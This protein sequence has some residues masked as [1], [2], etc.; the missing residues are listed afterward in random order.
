M[1]FFRIQPHLAIPWLHIETIGENPY[2]QEFSRLV[3]TVIVFAVKNS[4]PRAHHLD[5][6][7]ADDLL[8]PHIVFVD[9]ASFQWN[10]DD[11]HIIMGMGT[12]PFTA[13]DDIVI[14]HAQHPKPDPVRVVVTG[15]AKRLVADQPA[16]IGVPAGIGFM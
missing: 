6:A 5:L 10:A 15:E 12:K 16:M 3:G 7:L 9:K 1:P 11:L 2:L 4:F 8:V 14:Q 13:R